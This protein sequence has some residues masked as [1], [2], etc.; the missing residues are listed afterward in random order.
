MNVILRPA[1]ST[2]AGAVGGILHAFS[3]END[4]MPELH[5]GAETIAFCGYMIDQGWVTVAETDERVVGF[6]ALKAGEIHSL[7]LT[8]PKCGQGIGQRLLDY[9]KSKQ[10]KL[11]L[12][13]FQANHGACRFYERNGFTEFARSDGADN[14]E[15][16]PDVKYVWHRKGA[17]DG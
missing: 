9:A 5:S 17:A 16:L 13:A 1:H 6:L 4:W 3:R 8:P 2:D 15:N 12:F 7:Y 14:D 10:P 11:S